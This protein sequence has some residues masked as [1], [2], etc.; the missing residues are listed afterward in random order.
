MFLQNFIESI[1]AI[2]MKW[3]CGLLLYSLSIPYIKLLPTGLIF[4]YN[5]S[6]NNIHKRENLQLLTYTQSKK[7]INAYIYSSAIGIFYPLHGIGYR[8]LQQIILKSQ[9]MPCQCNLF[10]ILQLEY[11]LHLFIH[12]FEK[13]ETTYKQLIMNPQYSSDHVQICK[14]FW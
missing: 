8:Y 13:R 4:T 12:H 14:R 3:L 1:T 5:A 9:N 11:F 6:L 7:K 2:A 10:I